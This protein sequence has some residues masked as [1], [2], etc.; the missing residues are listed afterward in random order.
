MDQL[1]TANWLTIGD[2]S[3]NGNEIIKRKADG[4]G[5]GCSSVAANNGS[6]INSEL[7]TI[8]D[9]IKRCNGNEDY[10]TKSR[11]HWL[12]MWFNQNST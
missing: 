7:A 11:W 2:L 10:Q 12:G 9:L 5:W 4:T 8:G 3:C 6:V 1:L